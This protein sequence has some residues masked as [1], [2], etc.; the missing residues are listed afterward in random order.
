[1]K[2]INRWG[3][4]RNTRAENDTEHSQ[5][6]AM[7]AHAMALIGNVRYG[8]TYDP[9]FV[10][11]LALYHD[12]S[13][14][15]TGDMP[16]PVKHNNPAIKQEYR[17]LEEIANDRLLSMLPDDLRPAYAPLIQHDETTAEWRLVKAADKISAYLKCVEER[18]A[19]NLEFENAAYT[20]RT[21]ID[22]I[23]LP[24]VRDF[25]RECVPGFGMTLD[26]IS[27]G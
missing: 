8:R 20:I 25:M 27:G 15:I 3:L 9:G 22:Q 18:K 23:D 7:I 17:K 11:A 14:V 12:A 24:E 16:T 2:Y 19:G 4:M 26:E 21:S 13:E 1:M 5:Q 6:T 10:M